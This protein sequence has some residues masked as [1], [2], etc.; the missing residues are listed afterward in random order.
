[1]LDVS[2]DVAP[3]AV[4]LSEYRPPAFLIDKVDLVF[5]LED[6]DTRVKSRLGIRRNPA[7]AE[8]AAPLRLDGEELD[9]V[10]LA[11]DGEVLGANRYQ[12]PSE[13]GLILAE[14]PDAFT[15]EVETR[16]SPTNNT[17]LSGLYMSGGNSAPSASRKVFVASPISSTGRM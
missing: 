9:L 2:P 7:A 8:T 11:L 1:M 4:R 6:S 14:V 13:G 10:S 5:E 16:I 17:A 15:L 12:L 3:P